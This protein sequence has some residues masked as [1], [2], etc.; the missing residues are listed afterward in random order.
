MTVVFLLKIGTHGTQKR[1]QED[2]RKITSCFS[3][4]QAS[5]KDK[6]SEFFGYCPPFVLL[7]ATV[8]LLSVISNGSGLEHNITTSLRRRIWA[9]RSRPDPSPHI[10]SALHGAFPF[11]SNSFPL[12]GQDPNT[13]DRHISVK[14]NQVDIWLWL[15]FSFQQ[16]FRTSH[17]SVILQL[18]FE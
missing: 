15:G 9:N 5:K 16:P 17:L 7:D 13:S 14:A 1:D 8:E 12:V 3:W 2:N 11:L 10:I 6:Q 4:A 18:L